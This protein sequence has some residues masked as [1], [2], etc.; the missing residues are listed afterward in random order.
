MKK[1]NQLLS[2]AAANWNLND[3]DTYSA[4]ESKMRSDI[5]AMKGDN[6]FL[7]YAN[8]NYKGWQSDMSKLEEAVANYNDWY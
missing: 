7:R 6:D 5:E 1:L 3:Q 2:A 8:S 4:S